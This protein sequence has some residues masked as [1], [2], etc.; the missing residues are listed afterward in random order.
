MTDSRLFGR[1]PR[2]RLFLWCACLIAGA[3]QA[4]EPAQEDVVEPP[5][6]ER[7]HVFL[8]A[9][10]SNMAGRGEVA[11]E[12]RRGDPRILVRGADGHWRVAREPLHWDKPQAAGV[13]PGLAFARELLGTLPADAVVGL[14]PAAYGGTKI[15]AWQKGAPADV[16][17]PNGRGLYEQAVESARAAARDGSLRAVP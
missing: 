8:L 3:A 12:D 4:A 6:P 2:G 14:V 1:S 7:F 5:P 10:Q 11:D 16:A 15:E 17:W 13:G 9:G